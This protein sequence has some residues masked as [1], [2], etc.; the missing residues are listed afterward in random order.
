MKVFYGFLIIMVAVG[1]FLL[2]VTSAVYDFRTDLKEDTFRYETGAGVLTGNVTLLKAVYDNDFST[3]SVT[4]DDSDDVP[5]L[6]E[7]HT[8]NRV[9]DISGLAASTNRTLTVS[10]DV[11]ALSASGALSGFM[12]K[13]PWIWMIMVVCFPIAAIVYLIFGMKR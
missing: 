6:V 5:V 4:S 12:D 2:P 9:L 3:I 11:D 13:V 8:T 10:Y 1:L 7:Y